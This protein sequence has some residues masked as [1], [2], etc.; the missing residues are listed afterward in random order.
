[1]KNA[2][3]IN[4][5]GLQGVVLKVKCFVDDKFYA[6]KKF[7]YDFNSADVDRIHKEEVFREIDNLRQLDHPNIVKI[8]DLVKEN[9]APV[10][11]IELCDGSL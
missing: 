9:K 1:M 2:T 7:N 4:D 3:T 11:V 5:K 10:V 8:E 6:M